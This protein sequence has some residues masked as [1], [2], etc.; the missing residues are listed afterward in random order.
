M[1]AAA[2]AAAVREARI[3]GGVEGDDVAGGAVGDRDRPAEVD[4]FDDV[5][6]RP[7][8]H[9]HGGGRNTQRLVDAERFGVAHQHGVQDVGAEIGHVL[10]RTA[11]QVERLALGSDQA[12]VEERQGI[13]ADLHESSDRRAR[14]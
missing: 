11:A 5:R 8:E 4:R 3:D 9:G 1:R 7:F 6:A 10:H 13:A 14:P 2:Q 12:R